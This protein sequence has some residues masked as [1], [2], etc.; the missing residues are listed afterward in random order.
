[1]MTSGGREGL[2]D[3][4]RRGADYLVN[5]A[6]RQADWLQSLTPLLAIVV[7]GGGA[8]L[9]YGLSVFGPLV[10]LLDRLMVEP[11]L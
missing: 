5:R 7:I 10:E 6:R 4:L 1:M 11:Y 3:S 8:A 9:T 2:A